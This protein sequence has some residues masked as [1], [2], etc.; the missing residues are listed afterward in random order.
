LAC[1]CSAALP[2]EKNSAPNRASYFL[3]VPNATTAQ[4]IE[5]TKDCAVF[6]DMSLSRRSRAAAFLR[7]GDTN[8][9]A[10]PSQRKR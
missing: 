7:T 4:S 1:L 3:T 10:A 6:H 2:D 9:F 5:T 8:F